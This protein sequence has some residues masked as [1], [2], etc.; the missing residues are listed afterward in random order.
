MYIIFK[1][2]VSNWD[3]PCQNYGHLYQW[4]KEYK[5]KASNP[6]PS[7]HS[8]KMNN[9]AHNPEVVSRKGLILILLIFL[10]IILPM[11]LMLKYNRLAQTLI[12]LRIHQLL[13]SL[14]V[15][16]YFYLTNKPLRQLVEDEFVP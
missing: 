5:T 7:P 16:L 1:V 11:V 9:M 10:F 15:P 12:K 6:H 4:Y 2:Q 13:L 3:V 8:F 14:V